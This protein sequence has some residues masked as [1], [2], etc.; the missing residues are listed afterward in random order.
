MRKMMSV[1]MLVLSLG[2]ASGCGDSVQNNMQL[3]QIAVGRAK[4]EHALELA[5]KVLAAEPGH[6]E[7]A[8]IKARSLLQL[9]RLDAAQNALTAML[10]EHPQDV[11]LHQYMNR[12]AMMQID[13]MARHSSLYRVDAGSIIPNMEMMNKIDAAREIVNRETQWLANDGNLPAEA[14]FARAELGELNVRLLD[15]RLHLLKTTMAR[16][17]EDIRNRDNEIKQVEAEKLRLQE[18]IRARLASTLRQAPDHRAAAIRYNT[19]LVASKDWDNLWTF[20]KQ[21]SEQKELNESLASSMVLSLLQIPATSQPVADRISLGWK[22]TEAVPQARRQTLEWW[23][24]NA[25]LHMMSGQYAKAVPLL[26]QARAKAPKDRDVRYLLASCFYHQNQYEKANGILKELAV[27]AKNSANVALLYGMTLRQLGDSGAREAL[28][29]AIDLDPTNP[30]AR[31]QMILLSSDAGNVEAAQADL[32]QM[33]ER[34]PSDPRAIRFMLQFLRAEGNTAKVTE[35]LT[36]VEQI[37]PRRDEYL[38]T[39]VD[40]YVYLG[41]YKQAE[42]TTREWLS[43]HPEAVEPNLTLA[44]LMLAQN[45]LD[46]ANELLGKIKSKYA[47]NA[48]VDEIIGSLYL[49]QRQFDKAIEHL[50]SALDKT[51][52]NIS[53]RLKLAQAQHSL[54]LND[55]ALDNVEKILEQDPTHT[56]ALALAARIYQTQGKND[57][58]TEMLS[59][60]D[61]NKVDMRRNPLMAAQI[62]A[63][64]EQYDEAIVIANQA[65]F[66]GNDDPALRMLLAGVYLRKGNTSEAENQLLSLVRSQPDNWMGYSALATFYVQTNQLAKGISAFQGLSAGNNQLFGRLALAGLYTRNNQPAQALDQV[67]G[68]LKPMIDR[69][70]PRAMTVASVIASLHVTMKQPDRAKAVYQSMIDAKLNVP[71]AMLAMIDIDIATRQDP[72][73][74]VAKLDELLKIVPPEQRATSFQIVRRYARLGAY[75]KGIAVIDGWLSQTPDNPALL[76]TKG[77]LL[78]QAG[79]NPQAA[80]IYAQAVE[81]APDNAELWLRLGQAHTRGFNFPEAEKAYQTM[82]KLGTGAR[83]AALTELGQLYSVLGLNKEATATFETLDRE[84]NLRDPRIMFALG[85]AA[86]AIGK[87]DVAVK[88]LDQIPRASTLY[89][90]AQ[91]R[92]TQIDQARG[93]IED[94]RRRLSELARD[95]RTASLAAQELVRLGMRDKNSEEMLRWSNQML[96]LESLP[97]EQRVAWLNVRAALALK[98]QDWVGASRAFDDAAVVARPTVQAAASRVLLAVR[99]REFDTARKLYRDNAE[100]Q[101]SPLGAPLAMLLELPVPGNAELTAQAEYYAALRAGDAARATAAVQKLGYQQMSF[102]NDMLSAINRPDFNT[103]E[104]KAMAANLLTAELALAAGIPQLAGDITQAVLQTHHGLALAQ[105]VD[106]RA[107]G[108]NSNISR[109]VW[110]RI[111]KQVPGSDLALQASSQ[112]KL[113][114]KDFA[115]AAKDAAALLAREPENDHVEYRLAGLLINAKQHDDAIKLLEKL[116][117]SNSRYAPLACND[118]AYLLAIHQP[119]RLD[120]A[121][122]LAARAQQAMPR[123]AALLDTMGWINHLGG[124]NARALPLLVRA[125]AGLPASAE[126]HYHLG[127]VYAATGNNTWARYHLEAAQSLPEGKDIEGLTVAIQKVR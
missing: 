34:D 113:L 100:L 122:N 23:L 116:V 84:G 50:D 73:A 102:K 69:R 10:K 46:D 5:D 68:L 9:G 40:G 6:I 75:D 90:Q 47:E 108:A 86:Q 39:L 27:E 48:D 26:E 55:D 31:E 70:D 35:L 62:K 64:A 79:Q 88:N 36:R 63:R 37:N 110:E 28:R 17:D 115:G 95:R 93:R 53:T 15:R 71:Q 8:R 33:Y 121:R 82:A 59:R 45:R 66:A 120:E 76:A 98:S 80:A 19:A 124:D 22:L 117:N 58:A 118:L 83:A 96:S 4:F 7:A 43:R 72:K 16:T 41:Q 89:S 57:Q 123:N 30:V 77:N 14:E 49:Q 99:Q 101:S 56:E 109:D 103:P 1:G 67:Q 13:E 54:V 2:V 3:A 94:A 74:S 21:A 81:K 25:R 91:I 60:I 38:P 32:K 11:E 105:T 119:A 112:I 29:H 106:L 24:S 78:M 127:T 18:D 125:S 44:R 107:Q 20:L 114:D 12:C 61:V 51:P 42:Q 104:Y 111:V 85:S 126:V 87:Y 92:I 65:I 97:P 52:G